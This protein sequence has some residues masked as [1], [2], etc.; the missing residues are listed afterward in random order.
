AF[1][2]KPARRLGPQRLVV[3]R[4]EHE[5]QIGR[6]KRRLDQMPGVDRCDLGSVRSSSRAIVHRAPCTFVRNRRMS[7]QETPCG[8]HLMTSH[9]RD[10]G[11][12]ALG[13]LAKV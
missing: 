8:S 4:A 5:Q 11:S 13:I 12:S 10:Y 9:V 3:P 1:A 7:Q 6:L 2:P